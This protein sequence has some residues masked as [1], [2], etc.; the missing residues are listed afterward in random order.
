MFSWLNTKG[1]PYLQSSG[2][3][4]CDFLVHAFCTREG[5]V[6]EDD[7][8]SLNVSFREGD[9]EFRVLQNWNRLA[10]AF[11]IP[12][13]NFLVLN[14]VHRDGILVIP[15]RGEYFTSR[16][17]LNDDAIVTDRT[18][19]AICIKTADCV[20]VFVVDPERKVIAAIHAGWR[21]TAAGI[22]AKVVRLMQNQYG[23]HPSGLLAAIG[24]SIGP[25]C[26]EVDE[27]AA[28][29]FRLHPDEKDFLFPGKR[30]D[31]WMLDLVRAN[32]G[33]LRNCGIPE[34]GIDTSGLCTVCREDAFFSHRAA[35]GVTG[36]QIN[37]LMLKGDP[38][39]KA[40]LPNQDLHHIHG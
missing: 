16:E 36:R 12:V 33:Q 7:Y 31:R 35:G 27:P 1:I 3:A 13:E 20:P 14:Q 37:F 17:G 2:L 4:A 19:L 5:G 38:V 18:R 10:A 29:A 11:D 24:P 30:K 32:R 22:T 8:K 15:P 23:C 39:C 34:T 40:L 28:E 26:Y 21:G 25:C 6:S 9:E